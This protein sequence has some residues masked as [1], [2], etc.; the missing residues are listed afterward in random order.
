VRSILSEDSRVRKA[1]TMCSFSKTELDPLIA[2]G[3]F[4]AVGISSIRER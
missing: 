4:G 3:H 1:A 2:S